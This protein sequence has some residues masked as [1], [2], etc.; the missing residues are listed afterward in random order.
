PRHGGTGSSD[1]H[2]LMAAGACACPAAIASAAVAWVGFGQLPR[3][4]GRER[5]RAQGGG[6]YRDPGDGASW[7]RAPDSDW[8]RQDS[9]ACGQPL[10]PTAPQSRVQ[11]FSNYTVLAGAPLR[12]RTVDLLLTM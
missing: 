7:S 5:A 10:V 8:M 4:A 6:C 2:Q 3:M 12:N 1:G 11:I 9:G